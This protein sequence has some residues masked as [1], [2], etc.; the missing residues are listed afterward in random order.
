MSKL[1]LRLKHITSQFPISCYGTRPCWLHLLSRGGKKTL[2]ECSYYRSTRSNTLFSRY[3][4]SH[5]KQAAVFSFPHFSFPPFLIHPLLRGPTF[6][7][8]DPSDQI[9]PSFLYIKPLFPTINSSV[10]VLFLIGKVFTRIF[11]FR[12]H[13]FNA[14]S[15]RL[16]FDSSQHTWLV[17]IF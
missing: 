4:I 15:F 17:I 8:S 13:S 5:S 10:L 16:R 2:N 11:A 7:W 12:L 9:P 1:L 6:S 14:R 3:D